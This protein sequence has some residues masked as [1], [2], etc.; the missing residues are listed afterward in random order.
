MLLNF[1]RG[2][3]GIGLI[4]LRITAAVLLFVACGH[5]ILCRAMVV[6]FVATVLV[7]FIALGLFTSACSA[8]GTLLMISLYFMSHP[9]PAIT[10]VTGAVCTSVALMGAGAYSLD[11]LIYG[12]QRIVVPKS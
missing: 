1:P 7:I 8:V 3:S 11:A 6:S 5:E 9:A 4:V 2:R 12:R 10:T